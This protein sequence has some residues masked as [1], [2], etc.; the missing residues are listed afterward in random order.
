VH[1]FGARTLLVRRKV[2]QTACVFNW[3]VWP[4]AGILCTLFWR[5][6]GDEKDDRSQGFRVNQCWNGAVHAISTRSSG[7]GDATAADQAD[8]AEQFF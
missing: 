1:I 3:G 4:A 5:F 6:S 8:V 7:A 2:V